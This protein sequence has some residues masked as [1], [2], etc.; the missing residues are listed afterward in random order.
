MKFDS[1]FRG[2]CFLDLVTVPFACGTE[3][4]VSGEAEKEKVLVYHSLPVLFG[5]PGNSPGGIK[6]NF[7]TFLGTYREA[8]IYAVISKANCSFNNTISA[9]ILNVSLRKKKKVGLGEWC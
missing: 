5:L 4:T 7:S 2:C 9:I 8:L 3:E 1:L 6:T